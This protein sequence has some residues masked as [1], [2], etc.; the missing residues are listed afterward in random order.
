[1]DWGA[2][3]SGAASM[4]GTGAEI[5]SAAGP[6]GTAIGGAAGAVGGL[7]MGGLSKPN[8]IDE[9]H[10]PYQTT[11]MAEADKLLGSDLGAK[12]GQMQSAVQQRGATEEYQKYAANPEMSRNPALMAGVYNKLQGQ[13]QTRGVEDTLAG[14]RIDQQAHEQGMQMQGEA[15]KDALGAAKLNT[16]VQEYNQQPGFF[17][18]NLMSMISSASGGGL[19]KL[20]GAGGGGTNAGSDQTGGGL[21]IGGGLGAG[22][23]QAGGDISAGV[24]TSI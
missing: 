16:G 3:L 6:L 8:Q 5:G 11:M 9:Y 15:S 10:D 7:L 23:P 21:S 18:S 14:A 13:A 20:L 4:A 12:T 2:G 19:G 17:Q 22:V 24:P 1:M